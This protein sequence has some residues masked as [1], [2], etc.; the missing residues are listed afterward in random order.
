MTD[1]EP[2]D[3]SLS[4]AVDHRINE[5]CDRFEAALK[6]WLAEPPGVPPPLQI[7]ELLDQVDAS[8]RRSLFRALFVVELHYRRQKGEMTSP[9]GYASRFPEFSALIEQEFRQANDPQLKDACENS[10]PPADTAEASVVTPPGAM[11]GQPQMWRPGD[12]DPCSGHLQVRC[13]GCR[14]SIQLASETPIT[15]LICQSC[16]SHFSLVDQDRASWKQAPLSRLG[17]FQLIERL[18]AGGFG[19]VWRAHDLELDRTVAIKIPR[20]GSMTLDEQERFLHEARATAQLRHPNIVSVH[21]IGRD[22]DIVYIVSDLVRGLTLSDWI[23]AQP[24]NGREAANLCATIADAL[25]YAHEQ[26]IIHR[27]LKPANIMV[28]DEGEPHLMDFGLARREVNEVTITID[29][30]VLGTPAYMSPEQAQGEA[31]RVLTAAVT[32]IPSACS[33]S[34]Y[35]PVSF[36]SGA[37]PG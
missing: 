7:D 29:G 1:A 19:S 30:Q 2:Y 14:A 10:S 36:R 28:D 23:R 6:S 15:D 26:G 4:I 13:P 5:L 17:R 25:H 31:H 9:H 3:P 33:C 20:H 35:L 16:G 24:L 12:S 32:C 27:D 18:G 8:A 37:I 34:S 21:E 11:S 22:A